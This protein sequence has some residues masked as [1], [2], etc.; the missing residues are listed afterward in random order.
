LLTMP[1]ELSRTAYW[2]NAVFTAAAAVLE[3]IDAKTAAEMKAALVAY[4]APIPDGT[5]KSDGVKLG[6]AVAVKVLAA[7]ANDGS[8]APDAYRPRTTPGV[9][10]PARTQT[11]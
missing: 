10:V 9:Y 3:T 6:E 5:A 4:L 8:D 1:S 11:R 2:R 7:R